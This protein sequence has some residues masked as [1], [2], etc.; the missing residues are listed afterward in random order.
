MAYT[1]NEDVLI[2]GQWSEGFRL[3]RAQNPIPGYADP[4]MDGEVAFGGVERKI[5]DSISPDELE[6]FEFGIKKSLADNRIT[7]NAAIYRINWEGI[8]VLLTSDSGIPFFFNVGKSKSE[9]AELEVKTRLADNFQVDFGI[10]YGE[11]TLTEDAAGLGDNGDNLPGSG[12]FN[13]SLGLQYDFKVAD[14]IAFVRS[15]Y[16]YISEY[17]HNFA[18]DKIDSSTPASGG[19]GQLNLKSGVVINSIAI[20][21]FVNNLT[22][23]D[24]FTWVEAQFGT[25]SRAYRLRPRTIGM[26]LSYEF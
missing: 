5:P 8:P 1:P 7:L 6:S 17:Y 23:A 25:V 26:N 19:F 14:S 22:N 2:Y 4:D 20:D 9:G 12:D 24:D 13:F 15:D 10:S 11:A 21:L 18:E 3:G 16:S